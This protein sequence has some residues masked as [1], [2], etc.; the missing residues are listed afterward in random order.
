ML[1]RSLILAALVLAG[2][3][4]SA[5]NG[6]DPLADNRDTTVS[7]RKDFFLHANGGWFKKH[8]IPESEYMNGLWLTI[9][10]D[11]R[12]SVREICE[13]SAADTTA[14]PGSNRQKI[15]DF[16]ASGMDSAGAESA[17]LTPIQELLDEID[18]MKSKEDLARV[19]GRLHRGM[20]GSLFSMHVGKDDKKP[21]AYAIL[22]NQGGLGLPDRDYYF[23]TD[24]RSVTIR[25][26]YVKHLEFTASAFK[27]QTPVADAKTILS[28]ETALAKSSRV[29][30]ALRD[31]YANYNKLSA[32]E[33]QKLTPDFSWPVFFETVGLKNVDSVVVGQPEFFAAMQRALTSTPMASWKAYFKWCLLAEYSAYLTENLAVADFNFFA[34]TIRGIEQRKP[35]WKRVVEKTNRS[36]GELVGQEY[37]AHHVPKGAKEKL[38]E[39]GNTIR[40][41]CQERIHA[42]SWMG[43]STRAKALKKLE[44]MVMKVGYPDRW[45]DYSDLTID[46]GPYAA[47]VLRAHQWAFADMIRKWGKPVDRLEWAMTPQTY[48]AYYDPNNNEIVVPAANIIVPGFEKEL[49][50]DAILYGIIGGGTFGHEIIHGFDDMGSQYDETGR[51][52]MWWTTEDRERFT[53]KTKLLVDQCDNYVVLDSLHLR[54]QATLGENIADLGGVQLGYDAFKRTAQFKSGK[55]IAGLTP[56]ERFFLAYA[57]GWMIQMRPESLADQIMTDFHAPAQFRVNGPFSN[58]PEFY[59]TFHVVPG[60]AM[61][62]PD[63]L[64]VSIW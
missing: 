2:C 36:L 64:R 9:L 5:K 35:R 52:A 17:G 51:L 61:Y 28:L 54:G 24:S 20:A 55:R 43:D 48:N 60:D 6:P 50:D 53:A 58:V 33:L 37:V 10:E 31:P 62:R 3:Q 18:A 11:T 45:K 30:E 57:Y 56:N 39:I 49:P 26:E 15:G 7:P 27:S 1:Y 47:N 63:S 21:G 8:P 59:E 44:T 29:L 14:K 25:Q 42:I 16:F 41:V 46:R 40:D 32:S 23:K 13:T 38:L 34:K 4:P 22:L 19:A 12:K